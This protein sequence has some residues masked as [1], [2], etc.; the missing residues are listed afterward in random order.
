M[1]LTDIV[2]RILADARDQAGRVRANA[3]EQAEALLAAGRIEAAARAEAA[4]AQALGRLERE[5]NNRLAG[6]RLKARTSVLALKRELVAEIFTGVAEGLARRAPEEHAAFLAAL[7]P[8]EAAKETAVVNLGRGDLERL[9]AGFPGLVGAAL[10]R[11]HPHW[12]FTVSA[13]PGGFDAGLQVRDARSIHD[14]SLE[15][16]IAERR[17]P[18]ELVVA[19]ILFAP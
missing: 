5:R 15:T 9:G 6:V 16:L 10:A 17:T 3:T 4:L 7:V 12:G 2:D 11:R 19:R 13:E 8:A 1:A 14:F 18:W